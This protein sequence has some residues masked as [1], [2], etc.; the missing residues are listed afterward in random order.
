M[1]ALAFH[2][3]YWDY[4]GWKDPFAIP[5]NTA[6]QRGYGKTLGL[7]SIYTPKMVIND[8]LE[9]PGHGPVKPPR[10]LTK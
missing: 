4:I 5:A 9:G 10:K 1:I 2:F 3:A 7:R 8:R 6:L